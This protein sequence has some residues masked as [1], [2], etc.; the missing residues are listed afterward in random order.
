MYTKKQRAFTLLVCVTVLFVSLMSIIFIVKNTEHDCV[1]EDCPVCAEI[2]Q[3][4]NTLKT[5][6]IGDSSVN[7]IAFIAEICLLT[8]CIG[9]ICV[10][11]HSTPIA[12]KVRLNN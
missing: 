12:L 8:V 10:G 6:G 1:G 9:V 3:A 2:A 5:I 7:A 4:E 11:V